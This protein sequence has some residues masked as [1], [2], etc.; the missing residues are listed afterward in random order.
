MQKKIIRGS[1]DIERLSVAIGKTISEPIKKLA[2]RV[3]AL[4]VKEKQFPYKGVYQRSNEYE[5]GQ[6]TTFKGSI[7]YCCAEKTR[8]QP[9][10]GSDWQLAC[11]GNE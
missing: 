6:F 11:K 5:R 1:I 3:K 2:A 4:E 8:Q 9:G 7:W 10:S